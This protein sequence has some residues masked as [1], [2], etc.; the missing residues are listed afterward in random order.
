LNIIAVL[1]SHSTLIPQETKAESRFYYYVKDIIPG[2][3]PLDLLILHK[4][5]TEGG[6]V[7]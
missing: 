7:V 3:Y 1:D 2:L 6:L 5:E 4:N